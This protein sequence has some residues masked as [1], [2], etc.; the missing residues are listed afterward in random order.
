MELAVIDRQRTLYNKDFNTYMYICIEYER[1]MDRHETSEDQG[2]G[3][4]VPAR[5]S[6]NMIYKII[7]TF[8]TFVHNERLSHVNSTL[9][10]FSLA[11]HIV[12]NI[13]YCRS[14]SAKIVL[15][16]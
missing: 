5:N 10:S 13:A 7:F 14:G 12:A 1:I 15:I 11:E 9:G 8:H 16:F 2:N 3:S 6:G 4:L